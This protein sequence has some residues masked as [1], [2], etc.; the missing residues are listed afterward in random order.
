[1]FLILP[2]IGSHM[3]CTSGLI[4]KQSNRE[5]VVGSNPTVPDRCRGERKNTS[6]GPTHRV[7]RHLG[8]T[9]TRST[10]R[11]FSHRSF[12][13]QRVTTVGVLTAAISARV[14]SSSCPSS[15]QIRQH[16]YPRRSPR[17][18]GV[19]RDC[20]GAPT[21][22]ERVRQHPTVVNNIGQHRARLCQSFPAGA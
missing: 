15:V 1:M 8:T 18:G 3:G 2:V 13:Y 11:C 4:G 6:P 9:V 17:R 10:D 20:Y 19:Q 14:P 21:K 22:P 12:P 7:W 5:T 16:P